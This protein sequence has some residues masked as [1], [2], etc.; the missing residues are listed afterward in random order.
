MDSKFLN[1]KDI[2]ETCSGQILRS[3]CGTSL[4][5]LA[6]MLPVLLLIFLGIV[7]FGRAYY[8]A[9][10][11]AGAANAAAIYGSAYPTDLTG[12]AKAAALNAPDVSG[13]TTTTGWGCECSDGTNQLVNCSPSTPTC[14]VNV[15]YYVTVTT[16]ATFTPLIPW[17]GI[18]SPMTISRT[19]MMRGGTPY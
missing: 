9:P 12:M 6:I 5:E 3:E 18:P 4:V 19:T 11:V 14:S 8:L 1:T 17:P 2:F 16:S 13:L 15:V 7:D 10:E